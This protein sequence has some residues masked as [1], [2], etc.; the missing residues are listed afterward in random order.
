MPTIATSKLPPPKSWDEFEAIVCDVAILKWENPNIKRYGRRGQP[1]HGVDIIGEPFHLNNEYAGIQCKNVDSITLKSITDEIKKAESFD[2]PIKEFVIAH[3][4]KSDAVLESSMMKTST[5][6]KNKGKFGVALWSWEDIVLEL[7]SDSELVSKHYPQLLN[8]NTTDYKVIKM[9]VDSDISDWKYDDEEGIYTYKKDVNLR[10]ELQRK[11]E[12]FG[13]NFDE[14]WLKHFADSNG[15]RMIYNIYYGNSFIQKEYV[16]GVDGYRAYIP[17]PI[18]Q[19]TSNP[20]LTPW[21][22][23]FGNIIHTAGPGYSGPFHSFD[24][25]LKKA[26]I[27]VI[28]GEKVKD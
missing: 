3:T 6:R 4:G 14:P 15:H 22:Y 17:Y 7:A 2:P 26:N 24:H 27:T 20:K 9:I 8:T 5:D 1:Q 16:V 25:Y 21:R 10:I 12:Y 19:H 11:D 18:D 28:D 13:S 23:K